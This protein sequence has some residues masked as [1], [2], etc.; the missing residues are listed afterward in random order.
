MIRKIFLPSSR[1][2]TIRAIATDLKVP[3]QTL[4]LPNGDILVAEGA[5]FIVSG[6]WWVSLFPGAA[7]MLAVFTF[8]LLG[9]A[10]R[11][12]FDPRKRI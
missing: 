1:C 10:L 6:E 5:Q 7:L 2:W 8:N 12:V 4:V 11:D 9:D 3:R